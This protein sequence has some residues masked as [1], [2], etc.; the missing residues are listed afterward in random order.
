MHGVLTLSSFCDNEEGQ[1]LDAGEGIGAQLPDH[2]AVHSDPLGRGQWTAPNAPENAILSKDQ[3]HGA[4]ERMITHL[5]GI[6]SS[7]G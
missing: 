3:L 1:L 5:P 4:R 7:F 6:D 2:S